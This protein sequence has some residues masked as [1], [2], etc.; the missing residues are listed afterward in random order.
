[1]LLRG[2]FGAAIG[3]LALL[4]LASTAADREAWSQT[5]RTIRI[6]LGVPPGG[7]IDF[8][9]R[10]L[11]DQISNTAGQTVIVESKPGA[12]GTRRQ[13]LADQQQRHADQRHFAQGELRSAREL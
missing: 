10:L 5:G 6:V 1:M 12:R 11:A 4:V 7:S 9:A 3:V 13:H 2:F 8:L